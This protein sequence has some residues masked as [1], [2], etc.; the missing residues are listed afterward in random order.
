MYLT[1]DDGPDPVYTPQILDVLK[2]HEARATFFVLGSLAAAYPEIVD[3]VVAEGHTV[4]NHTW[5]HEYLPAVS[6]QVFDE[7]VGETQAL[8]GDRA[9]SCLRPPYGAVSRSNVEWAG[10]HGLTI[11]NW[12]V[13]PEDWRPQPA[14]EIANHIVDHARAGSVVVLHDGGTNRS[15]TVTAVDTALG[16]LAGSGLRF[17]PLC[18]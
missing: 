8:L 13:D 16:R 11:T 12:N 17:E 2:R 1:F 10:E 15:R 18:R 4:A 7:T 6:R 3:R 14:A 5:S 9:T